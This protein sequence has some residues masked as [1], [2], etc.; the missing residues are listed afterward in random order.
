MADPL[1]RR[2]T[3]SRS[4]TTRIHNEMYEPILISNRYKKCSLCRSE[5][6]NRTNCPYK[7][8]HD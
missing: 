5:G 4:A 7:Q 2:D 3:S 8:V 6:H 1:K